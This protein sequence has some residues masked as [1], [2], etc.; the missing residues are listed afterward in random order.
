M[1]AFSKRLSDVPGSFFHAFFFFDMLQCCG[2]RNF[3][4][5]TGTPDIAWC[6]RCDFCNIVGETRGIAC[7][8]REHSYERDYG[9]VWL[10]HQCSCS[11]VLEKPSYPSYSHSGFHI[12]S[13]FSIIITN[14]TSVFFILLLLPKIYL[15]L[16]HAST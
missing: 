11:P 12:S 6:G 5:E 2:H 10:N 3:R 7:H 1:P 16:L 14:T 8:G 13:F 15:P 9:R 4:E